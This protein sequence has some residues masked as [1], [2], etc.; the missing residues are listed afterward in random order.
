MSKSAKYLAA[1]FIAVVFSFTLVC[2]PPVAVA[3]GAAQRTPA[4][5]LVTDRT[6]VTLSDQF[7]SPTAR[8]LTNSGNVFFASTAALFQW[9]SGSA[10]RTRMLQPNDPIPGITGSSAYAVGVGLRINASGHAAMIN[11]WSQAGIRDPGGIFV[12]VGS[13]YRKVVLS[14][15]ATPGIADHVFS[16][17]TDLRV[18]DNDQVAF[19]ADFEPIGPT[20]TGIFLGSPTAPPIKIFAA[21]DTLPV[22]GGTCSSDRDGLQLIGVDNSGRVAFYCNTDSSSVSRALVIGS[23]SGLQIALTDGANAPGTNTGFFNLQSSSNT[24]VLNSTGDLAIRSDIWNDPTYYA[25]IWIRTA[26]GSL[27]EV[28]TNGDATGTSIGGTFTGFTLA[29][30]D[31][32]GEVLFRSALTGG[33]SS[34]GL[35]LKKPGNAT[36]LVCYRDQA[37]PGRTEQF[38]NI[39]SFTIH[40]NGKALIVSTLKNG[41]SPRGLFLGTGTAA[42]QIIA[43]QGEATPA[44]GTFGQPSFGLSPLNDSD[45]VVFS[46]DILGLNANGLFFWAP[47]AGTQA[48]VSTNDTLPP[49][50]N[51][52]L[53]PALANPSDDEIVLQMNKAGGQPAYFARRLQPGGGTIRRIVGVGDAAPGGGVFRGISPPVINDDEEVAFL[54][55]SIV[56]GSS[57]PQGAIWFSSPGGGLQRL[58]TTGDAA[59]G[60]AGGTFSSFGGG[61]RINSQGQVAFWGNISGSSGGTSTAGI[62][63]VSPGGS[64][65]NIVRLG[66]TSPASGTFS[67]IN[68]T[69]WLNDSGQVAFYATSQYGMVLKDGIFV[70]SAAASPVKVVVYGDPYGSDSFDRPDSTFRINNAGQ[71]AFIGEIN[72]LAGPDH[73]G[74]FLATPGETPEPVV[75]EGDS[76]PIPGGSTF[77]S[78][79]SRDDEI[80]LNGNGQVA[81]W[82]AWLVGTDFGTGYFTGSPGNAP[83][84]RIY[85][86]MPVPG[87]GSCS[88]FPPTP[89]ALTSAVALNNSGDLAMYIPYIT[90]VPDM[91]RFLIADHSGALTDLAVA[92]NSA[93]GTGGSFARFTGQAAVNSSGKFFIYAAMLGGADDLGLF[94]NGGVF[95]HAWS[96]PYNFDGDSIGD[97]AVWRPDT[98]IWYTLPSNSPGGFTT[99]QWGLP[100]DTAAPADYDGDS[101]TDIAVWRPSTG[102]WYILPSSAPGT[103]TTAQ[104]GIST[105]IPVPGDYDGDGRADIAVWRPSTGTWYILPSS[106][107][108]TYT[109]AQWGIPSDIPVPGDYDG[110]G[111]TDIAVWRASSGIWYILRSSAPGYIATQWGIATDTPVPAD[112][113]GDG[114]TDIAVWR[115]S[116]GLW[117]VI[118]SSAPESY[119]A[120]QWGLPTDTLITGDYDRDGKAD[121][122]V[123]RA[124]AGMWYVLPSATPGSYTVTQWGVQ[125]DLPL[126]ALTRILGSVH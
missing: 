54:T 91:P 37:V 31:D 47:G 35:F 71:V 32:A 19:L 112:Y 76:V 99:T 103:Y 78:F 28:F 75:L 98:G 41:T 81:F 3:Q 38:D 23:A 119:T 66:D 74:V 63:I 65:Q 44:G 85:T 15:E 21:G 39:S 80:E 125:T 61:Y 18:N 116:A 110:D 20:M 60:S 105:D 5:P 97:I 69:F 30:I 45:Q 73:A 55:G 94:W 22:V 42:P 108:G 27:Q 126:S 89:N 57:Y 117:Y 11:N 33:T 87:G 7:S 90:G 106:A 109:T 101:K 114:K 1:I 113:D 59:P 68:T 84:A 77:L 13:Q 43:L 6:N 34:Q 67:S 49:G 29:G 16:S 83:T 62:F 51:L 8:A 118:P 9:N 10:T 92:G 82:A 79:E 26:A 120:T 2:V 48:I 36:Q 24:Y 124:S 121:I 122:G 12:Y 107:P 123:Y 104:W 86:G 102:I 88:L 53:A 64:V 4:L 93:Y 58:V 96:Q 72:V 50:S 14:G 25:G 52:F 111:K 100:T 56:G 115:G 46:S 70:G 40:R 17:F 95:R